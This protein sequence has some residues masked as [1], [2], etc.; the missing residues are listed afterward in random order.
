MNKK[1]KFGRI[2]IVRTDRIGDVLLSTPVIKA[3]RDAYPHS[4][5]A[6]MVRP[7]AKDI[8]NENPFLNEVIIYDKYG[9]H[10][11]FLSSLKFA[12]GLRKKKFDLAI[13][14][15]PTNRTHL[16]TWLAGISTRIGFDKK[17]PFLLTKTVAH[18]KHLGLM[19]EIDYGFELL[20]EIGIEAKNRTLFMPIKE[21]DLKWVENLFKERKISE[22]KP[23]FCL[24]PG[25]SCI[26]KKWPARNF[27]RL[28]DE[29]KEQFEAQ[30]I[31]FVG[32]QDR[33]VANNVYRLAKNKPHCMLEGVPLGKIAALLKKSNLLI[34]NDSGPVHISCAV[35]TPVVA[36]FG[37]NQPG[38][39]PKRWG[40]I[41]RKDIVLH[42]D[43]GCVVCLAHN[44][45]RDFECL[46]AIKTEDVLDA[47][48][49]ILQ[50]ISC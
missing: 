4:F 39:S 17:L 16:I 22:N 32:R 15:H 40:P 42:K 10:R 3:V 33:Q 29:L 34:S 31:I 21:N 14:L 1:I 9:R 45:Q 49:E 13:I 25:A 43:V 50:D 41:G 5:I 35:G 46:K 28:I 19:H 2:L 44:C 24:H 30:I 47:V 27:A 48:R 20:K 38:L 6:M 36:I 26:S 12:F 7:Y 37:R 23:I 11:S 8:V 18:T